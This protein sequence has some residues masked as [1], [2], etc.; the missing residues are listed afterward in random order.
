MML[1]KAM[2][3]LFSMKRRNDVFE[4]D[5]LEKGVAGERSVA[6]DDL[7]KEVA[8]E[9]SMAENDLQKRVAGVYHSSN[10]RLAPHSTC[11]PLIVNGLRV[12]SGTEG[13]VYSN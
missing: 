8:G 7:Q 1:E 13:T 2:M 5:D 4:E 10:P 12:G 6:E 9:H 11:T 3:A